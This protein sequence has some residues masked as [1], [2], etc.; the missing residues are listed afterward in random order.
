MS[1]SVRVFLFI[2]VA[3][4]MF[5]RCSDVSPEQRHQAIDSPPDNGSRDDIEPAPPS[6]GGGIKAIRKVPEAFLDVAFFLT[7]SIVQV[8]RRAFVAVAQRC[9]SFLAGF[10]IAR[11]GIV[12]ALE[13]IALGVTQA[14]V[15]HCH[16]ASRGTFCVVDIVGY[17]VR[18]IAVVSVKSARFVIARYVAHAVIEF[19]QLAAGCA[20]QVLKRKQGLRLYVQR[21]CKL[22][23][24]HRIWKVRCLRNV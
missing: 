22:G 1:I 16:F 9:C 23:H 10:F 3:M 12:P 20:A 13:H 5:F 6:R 24:I 21:R 7:K 14:V 19:Q 2:S 8:M 11:Q 17:F 15:N 18:I 4:N